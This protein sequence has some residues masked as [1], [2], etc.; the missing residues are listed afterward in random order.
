MIQAHVTQDA[1]P[2]HFLRPDVPKSLSGIIT[3]L[4]QKVT[5]SVIYS[6][7][8]QLCLP[9]VLLFFCISKQLPSQRYKSAIGVKHDLEEIQQY[10]TEPFRSS[11]SV[12]KMPEFELGNNDI[13]INFSAVDL[14]IGREYEIKYVH[15]FFLSYLLVHLFD[16]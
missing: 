3:K 12:R 4:M 16:S 5:F 9:F 13:P 10:V 6:F 11:E 7:I 2:V 8:Y 1:K 14:I 15:M